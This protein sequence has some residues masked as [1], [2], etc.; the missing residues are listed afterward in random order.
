M[1]PPAPS[2]LADGSKGLL[3][4]ATHPAQRCHRRSKVLVDDLHEFVLGC[5][6]VSNEPM[7]LPW[8][9]RCWVPDIVEA[10]RARFRWPSHGSSTDRVTSTYLD[11]FAPACSL[12]TSSRRR[13]LD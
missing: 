3:P 12:A 13:G 11:R 9:Q 8:N 4:G 1:K 2:G 10:Q 5:P 6:F 7:V